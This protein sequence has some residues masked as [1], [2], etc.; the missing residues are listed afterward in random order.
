LA[1]A[2][3]ELPEPPA[4]LVTALSTPLALQT[5]LAHPALWRGSPLAND[6]RPVLATGWPQ[7]DAVLPGAGWPLGSLIEVAIAAPGSGECA[8]FL[9]ALVAA[10]PAPMALIDPPFLPYAP[11]W[12]QAGIDLSQ[13]WWV[14]VGAER[15]GWW[16]AEQI[17]RSRVC[18]AVLFWPQRLTDHAERRLQLAAVAGGSIGLCFRSQA[19]LDRPSPAPLRLCLAATPTHWQVDLL[20]CRGRSGGARVLLPRSAGSAVPTLA[21]VR[22]DSLARVGG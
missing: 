13:L 1:A 15:D 21:G 14:S 10:S 19:E 12:Q 9:P 2:V 5:L 6:A 22:G 11:G 8:L 17:L 18:R 3:D 4:M 20:K 16:A 7:L